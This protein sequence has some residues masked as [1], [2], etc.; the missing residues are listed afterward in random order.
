M[1][2]NQFG[3]PTGNTSEIT[4]ALFGQQNFGRPQQSPF[5]GEENFSQQNLLSS[6]NFLNSLQ[7]RLGGGGYSS[8]TSF[9]P[10]DSSIAP[11]PRRKAST[12]FMLPMDNQVNTGY[13]SGIAA[14]NASF[15][16]L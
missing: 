4:A 1:A 6:L 14:T 5:L 11:A 12:G 10:M 7:E 16:G 9:N 8:P 13:G 3:N 15:L 2:F